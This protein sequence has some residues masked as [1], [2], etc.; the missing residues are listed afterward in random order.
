M[1]K[2]CAQEKVAVQRNAF[3]SAFTGGT[4]AALQQKVGFAFGLKLMLISTAAMVEAGKNR[5]AASGPKVGCVF[6]KPALLTKF[7]VEF[8]ELLKL[9][10][11]QQNSQ[12]LHFILSHLG[13]EAW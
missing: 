6:R 8:L 10:K 4:L 2:R 11:P 3:S 12:L 9:V 7:L 5:S 13:T 1:H